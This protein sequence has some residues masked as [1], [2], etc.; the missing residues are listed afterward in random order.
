MSPLERWTESMRKAVSFVEA[1][2]TQ[3]L[4]PTSALEQ[5]R[6]GGGRIRTQ[7]WYRL[8]NTYADA[9]PRQSL[10]E[11][12]PESFTIPRTWYIEKDVNF[13]ERY[14]R[15][16][17]I[18]P[19]FGGEIEGEDIWRYIESDRELTKQEWDELTSQALLSQNQYLGLTGF[20]IVESYWYTR[21]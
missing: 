15:A 19:I 13:S 20:K 7:D 5:Y 4:T 16:V 21:Q 3:S 17:R 8:W 10:I 11:K 1:A 12:M 6:E 14:V 9:I 18:T 2:F